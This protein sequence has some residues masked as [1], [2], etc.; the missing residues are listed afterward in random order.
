MDAWIDCMTS[1]DDFAAGMSKIHAPD[2]DMVTLDLMDR[3]LR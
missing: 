1:L 2:G 3:P